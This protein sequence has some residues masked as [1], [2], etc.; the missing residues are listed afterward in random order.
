MVQANEACIYHMPGQFDYAKQGVLQDLD[1]LMAQDPTFKDVWEGNF[2]ENSKAWTPDDP[3]ATIFLP[4]Y[5]GVRVIHW[6]A[7]LFED[8]G[9]EPLSANPRGYR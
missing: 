7:K 2:L 8:W 1:V 9:V 5:T 4:A 3:D 6:D